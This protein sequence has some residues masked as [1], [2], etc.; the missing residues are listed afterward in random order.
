[1]IAIVY[2]ENEEESLAIYNKI[3]E[4]K[5]DNTEFVKVDDLIRCKLENKYELAIFLSPHKSSKGVSS[6]TVHAC[7]NW[8]NDNSYGGLPDKLSMAKPDLMLSMLKRMKENNKRSNINVTY[9]ATHHGPYSDTPIIFAEFMDKDIDYCSSVV[10][11]SIYE[12]LSSN[13]SY[14]KIAVGIGS[15]HYPIRFTKLALEKSYAFSHIMPK[16]HINADMLSDAFERSD[17]KAEI[18]VI[19][20][21]SLNSSQFRSIIDTLNRLG[22]DYE[23]Y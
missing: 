18:A 1:M 13:E 20:K 14:N 5:I 23:I 8:S 12:A 2:T 16:Y 7:G 4:Y 17:P 11:K 22:Y 19:E 21:S 9:E 6:F 3:K 15:T 10:A